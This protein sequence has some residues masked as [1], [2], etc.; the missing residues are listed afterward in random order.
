MR[1]ANGIRATFSGIV[2]RYGTKSSYGHPKPTL[3]LKDIKDG[4]GM[5]VTEHLW[6]NLT[7]G[8]A[9]L[10]LQPGDAVKF[11]ARVKPY[12]KGYRG[13]R[14]DVYDKPIEEDYKLS[15]PTNLRKM[16][17]PDVQLPT[18]GVS[19]LITY[20]IKPKLPLST[21]CK[22]E[23]RHTINTYAASEGLGI[24]EAL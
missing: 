10:G 13:Y 17:I 24:A 23:P 18:Q 9:K 8:F 16:I 22:S 7:Q 20:Y 11:D 1:Q 21:L 19:T 4:G 15:H 5:I 2:E 14:D 3:L 6:F 12:I